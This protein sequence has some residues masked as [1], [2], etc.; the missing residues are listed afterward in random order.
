MKNKKKILIIAIGVIFL[1]A[2]I[3]LDSVHQK[4]EDTTKLSPEEFEKK[5]AKD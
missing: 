5:Y 4:V 2:V 1:G 3:Y